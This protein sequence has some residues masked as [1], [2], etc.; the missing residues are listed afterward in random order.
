VAEIACMFA[1]MPVIVSKRSRLRNE[2]LVVA[3]DPTT[4]PEMDIRATRPD[5]H[6]G[7]AL[8]LSKVLVI[9]FNNLKDECI[10]DV[11]MH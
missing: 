4:C 7:V 6:G 3:S 2:S 1:P 8:G 10:V 9:V 5:I 11:E